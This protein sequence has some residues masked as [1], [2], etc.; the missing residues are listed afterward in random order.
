MPNWLLL[1]ATLP[2]REASTARVRLWRGLKELGA[3]S[4][5]DGVTLVPE[6]LG[7]RDGLSKVISD[8]QADDGSAW[9]F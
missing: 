1:A 7:T 9:L 4:A 5:R 8:I 6:N 2:G 3:A